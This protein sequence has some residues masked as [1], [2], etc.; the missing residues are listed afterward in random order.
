MVPPAVPPPARGELAKPAPPPAGAVAGTLIFHN[1]RLV[2]PGSPELD[3]ELHF[4]P[5][6][7]L[8]MDRTGQRILRGV[9]YALIA[10]AEY[11]EARRR[12]F[13]RTLRHF[14]VLRGPQ[15]EVARLR[16]ERE[17]A[18]EIVSSLEQRWGKTV[19]R[20]AAQDEERP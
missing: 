20:A 16:L 15:G 18:A 1:V 5:G 2:R 4:E 9:P 10:S 17:N 6:R 14:L 8:I 3:V 13:V 11:V 19:A 12:L 7:L